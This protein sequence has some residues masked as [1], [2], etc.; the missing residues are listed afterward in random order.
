MA[1]EPEKQMRIERVWAMPNSETFQVKPIA[2]FVRSYLNGGVSVDPFARDSKLAMVTNDLNPSTSAD[3]HMDAE[4]FLK[5]LADDGVQAEVVIIDPPYSPRQVKECYDK[6]GI[7]MKQHE[8][9]LG[10]TRG[11]LREQ[12][13]RILGPGGVVLWFGWNTTGM[14]KKYG[15]EIE[16]I[17]LV[18]HGSDHNDTICFAER[19]APTAQS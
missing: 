15:F 3:Y 1:Y 10:Y 12:I 17:L 5:M 8:A 7:P 4:E 19:R 14:G 9:L 16:Q 2:D 13:N 18:C 6:I 11:R